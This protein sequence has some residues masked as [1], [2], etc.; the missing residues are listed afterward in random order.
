V[1]REAGWGGGRE[2]GKPASPFGLGTFRKDSR[3]P[4]TAPDSQPS[5]GR[6]DR[7]FPTSWLKDARPAPNC[8]NLSQ[9]RPAEQHG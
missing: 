5:A 7:H 3:R 4:G 6:P 8:E 2:T 9:E 1:T